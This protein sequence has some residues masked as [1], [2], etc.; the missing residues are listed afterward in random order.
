MH[1]TETESVLNFTLTFET[2]QQALKAHL[3]AFGPKYSKIA[4]KIERTIPT[5]IDL[6]QRETAAP[7]LV[8]QLEEMGIPKDLLPTPGFNKP[9]PKSDRASVSAEEV[10]HGA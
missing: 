7:D 4:E 3:A 9:G 1:N 8:K 2:R 5:V 10:N 6:C